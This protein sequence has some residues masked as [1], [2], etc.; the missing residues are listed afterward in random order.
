MPLRHEWARQFVAVPDL[1]RG[2]LAL[3]GIALSGKDPDIGAAS[4]RATQA[5][6]S[7]ASGGLDKTTEGAQTGDIWTKTG[8]ALRVF[9]RGKDLDL[10]YAVIIYNA[11]LDKI[12]L[13]PLLESEVRLFKDGNQ[14][15]A[16][17]FSP[18]RL[19]ADHHDDWKPI[20]F[21]GTMRLTHAQEPGQYV[22]QIVIVDRLAKERYRTATQWIDF[23]VV[24]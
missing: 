8:P 12:S 22:L 11:H 24:E 9:R 2:R 6:G 4:S 13:R 16:S 20:A 18:G 14:V 3:S 10:D 21:G 17:G 19:S 1:T 23:E 7:S 5:G 15:Y